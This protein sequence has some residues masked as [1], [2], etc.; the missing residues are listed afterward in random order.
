MFEFFRQPILG[1]CLIMSDS[2]I[3][4]GNVRH[5]STYSCRIALYGLT[6]KHSWYFLVLLGRCPRCRRGTTLRTVKLPGYSYS[7]KAEGL[8]AHVAI[9]V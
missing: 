8:R 3:P 7:G 4:P 9:G 5:T 2:R 6:A 1:R